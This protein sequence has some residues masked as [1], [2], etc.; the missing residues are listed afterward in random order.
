[1]ERKGLHIDLKRKIECLKLSQ[2]L[3]TD[4][5]ISISEGMSKGSRSNNF[6]RLGLSCFL[7]RFIISVLR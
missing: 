1:M 2:C 3:R 5:Q 7:G 6:E 4:S